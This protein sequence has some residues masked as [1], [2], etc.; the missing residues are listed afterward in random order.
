V[1]GHTSPTRGVRTI[2]TRK[3]IRSLRQ[4][5]MPTSPLHASERLPGRQLRLRTDTGGTAVPGR[6]DRSR[7]TPMAG[8]VMTD[9]LQAELVCEI[10]EMAVL[11]QQPSE[12]P[13]LPLQPQQCQ[14]LPRPFRYIDHYLPS[15]QLRTFV[16]GIG[17]HLRRS[18]SS[19]LNSQEERRRS[20]RWY[21][22][23]KQ[24]QR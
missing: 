21:V 12:G 8:W 23:P 3:P 16:P 22:L 5:T 6:R 17:C 2:E 7:L 1:S 11:A 14:S 15:E 24:Y 18:Q 10:L 20:S 9:H 13:T 19:L 4:L